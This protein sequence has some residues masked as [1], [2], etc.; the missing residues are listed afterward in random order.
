M[1]CVFSSFLGVVIYL[2]MFVEKERVWI[3]M[4]CKFIDIFFYFFLRKEKKI[5]LKIMKDYERIYLFVRLI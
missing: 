1:I 5:I 3:M 4:C 2:V